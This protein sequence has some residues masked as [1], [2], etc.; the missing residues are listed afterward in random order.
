MVL[1]INHILDDTETKV[2]CFVIVVYAFI[3]AIQTLLLLV[4]FDVRRGPN[5]SEM[6]N[7]AILVILSDLF[8]GILTLP[9]QVVVVIFGGFQNSQ[10][11]CDFQAMQIFYTHMIS[12]FCVMLYSISCN[13]RIVH[14]RSMPVW[15]AIVAIIMASIYLLALTITPPA[16]YGDHWVP[17]EAG[18]YCMS[19]FT[20]HTGIKFTVNLFGVAYLGI[21]VNVIL[22]M[23]YGIRHKVVKVMAQSK[24]DLDSDSNILSLTA[25]KE[26]RNGRKGRKGALNEVAKDLKS[27]ARRSA[28]IPLVFATCWSPYFLCVSYKLISGQSIPGWLDQL[29]TT[30]ASFNCIGDFAVFGLLNG[31]Y[32]KSMLK[33]MGFKQKTK[34][35]S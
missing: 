33:L 6:D 21:I 32:R 35:S 12:L 14:N 29:T 25:V 27:A 30:F 26:T 31:V 20:I 19:D 2:A 11:L 24:S 17:S 8:S 5:Q 10:W 18:Y 16:A 1:N 3:I 23:Y 13:L 9:V 34:L 4:W 7:Y 15:M 28:L 22:F